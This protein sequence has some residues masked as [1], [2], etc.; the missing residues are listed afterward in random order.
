MSGEL[1]ENQ[2]STRGRSPQVQP[3]IHPGRRTAQGGTLPGGQ[4]HAEQ[5]A[6]KKW[7]QHDGRHGPHNRTNGQHTGNST[8]SPSSQHHDRRRRGDER[9]QIRNGAADQQD[10][11][12]TIGGRAECH[13]SVRI[14][15]GDEHRP[16]PVQNRRGERCDDQRLEIAHPLP[17]FVAES[18][19]EPL[20]RSREILRLTCRR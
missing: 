20:S 19:R 1:P 17:I 4:D 10:D 12:Q 14:G 9:R 8:R 16:H 2:R 3:T 13:P 18:T 6:A 11:T 5:L 7:A 15:D